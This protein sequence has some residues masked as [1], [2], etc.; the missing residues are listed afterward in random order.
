MSNFF[1]T[2]TQVYDPLNSWPLSTA[3]AA[4]PVLTLF[5]VLVVVKARVWVSAL[6]GLLAALLLAALV[7][8]MPVVLV[9]AAAGHG[10]IF[11]MIR[12]AWVIVASIFLY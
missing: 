3:V 6:C 5:F 8:K 2:W 11:G 1:L 12:I 7:F 10:F 9:A 4:L